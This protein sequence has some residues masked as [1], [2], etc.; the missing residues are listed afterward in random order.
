MSIERMEHVGIVVD[1]L[2][3]AT[4]FFVELGLVLGGECA[5][6]G[7]WVDR[8]VGLEG[9][10]ADIAMLETPDGHSRLEL[11]KY[12]SPATQGENRLAPAN[13][14][15]IRHIA[16]AVDDIDAVIARLRARGAELVGELERYQDKYLLC[17]VR[18]PEGIIIELAEQIGQPVEKAT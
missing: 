5:V 10:R 15:G 3:A 16:F 14:S 4:E 12:H 8:V 1:D 9:V 11:T 18:G 6:E 13:T 17:Y 2:A 7:R